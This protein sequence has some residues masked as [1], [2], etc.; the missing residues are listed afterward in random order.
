MIFL[1]VCFRALKGKHLDAKV[2]ARAPISWLD[3]CR[4][5]NHLIGYISNSNFKFKFSNSK[6]TFVPVFVAKRI[7]KTHQHFCFLCF[8]SRWR[9]F[10]FHKD[11]ENTKDLFTLAENNFGERKLSCTRLNFSEILFAGTKRAVPGGQYRPILLA[12]VANQNTEF[13]AYCPLAELS[14][15]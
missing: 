13:A 14:I 1:L 11:R 5:Y 3:K 15:I 9:F 4:I 8:H 2:M 6:Q 10:W 7:F 12:R